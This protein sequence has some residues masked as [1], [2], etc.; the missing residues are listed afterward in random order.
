M[1]QFKIFIGTNHKPVIK[2]SNQAI[3]ERIRLVPFIV[4]IP[5]K[6]RDKKL[7]D[8]LQAELPGFSPG[9]CMGA[10]SGNAA[11]IWNRRPRC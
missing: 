8:A 10:W 6:E 1:P 5:P 4:H 7:D 9:P 11:G 2:D 3:W